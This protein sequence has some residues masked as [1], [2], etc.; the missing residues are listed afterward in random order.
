MP[1][2]IDVSVWRAA[3]REEVVKFFTRDRR[4][5]SRSKRPAP[6][7]KNGLI[8]RTHLRPVDTYAY[9]RARFGKP[10]GFQ[11][12]LRNDD[13]DN[14][15]HWDF[16]LKADDEDIHI[17]GTSRNVHILVSEDLSDPD[18]KQ[19]I[20]TLKDEFG[21]LGNEKSAI[22]KTFEK[23]LSFQNKFVRISGLC[24]ERHAIIVDADPPNLT[25]P[26][27]TSSKR[28]IRKYHKVLDVLGK[29]AT[30]LYGNCLTLRLLTPIMAE[31]YFNM[32]ILAFCKKS[33][34]D[35]KAAYRA[36]VRAKIPRRIELIAENC[37]G[38]VAVIRKDTKAYADFMRVMNRRNFAIHGNMDPEMEQIETVYFEG[39]RPLFATGGD[40]I[41]K[42]FEHLEAINKPTSVVRD[43]EAVHAFLHEITTYLSPR[44]QRFFEQVISDPYPGYE[45]HKKRITRILPNH[46][47]TGYLEGMRY[48]DELSVDW[49]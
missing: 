31:A 15:I 18:W 10:N 20:L 6:P 40:N 39:R 12:F 2:C 49:V 48:D 21:R 24:A 23:Y 19:L 29:R 3:T 28:T 22:T 4:S 33:I 1:R 8:I 26:R 37:D 36:F 38:F 43:Y 14:W 5:P 7:S 11:N 16:N 45:V 9:L 42:L 13:S 46:S 27:S 41:L 34:L 35:D 30:A 32:L 17:A 25:L 47:M 44:H